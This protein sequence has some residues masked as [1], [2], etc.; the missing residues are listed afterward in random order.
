MKSLEDKKLRLNRMKSV[1]NEMSDKLLSHK[2]ISNQNLSMKKDIIK[3]NT[4]VQPLLN[5]EEKGN[6]NHAVDEETSQGQKP[7][8]NI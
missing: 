8:K 1:K 4:L 5:N 2:E 6:E 3:G 7:T